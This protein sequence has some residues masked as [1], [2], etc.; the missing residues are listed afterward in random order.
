MPF[1]PPSPTSPSRCIAYLYLQDVS[2]D[3]GSLDNAVLVVNLEQSFKY[4]NLVIAPFRRTFAFNQSGLAETTAATVTPSDP[5]V[6]D[7]LVETQSINISPYQIG[8][9]YQNGSGEFVTM[10]TTS[11]IQI[12]NQANVD[13]STLL[14]TG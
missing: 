1:S 3:I 4:G 12:P 9:Q 2:G 11:N 8:V 7:G 10:L 5:T 6:V 14:S 13:L